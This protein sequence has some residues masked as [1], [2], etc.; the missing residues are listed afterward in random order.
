MIAISTYLIGAIMKKKLHLHHSLY[1]I[2]QVLSV[3]LFEKRPILPLFS[4]P[5]IV[6]QKIEDQERF[7]LVELL[8]E[9]HDSPI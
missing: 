1:S 6:A 2:L 8:E 9:N 7:P 5:D 4:E 3:T